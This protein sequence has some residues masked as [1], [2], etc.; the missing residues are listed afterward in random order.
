MNLDNIKVEVDQE[1]NGKWLGWCDQYQIVLYGENEG[2][3]REKIYQVIQDD[4][5]DIDLNELSATIPSFEDEDRLG[6][7]MIKVILRYLNISEE[8][9]FKSLE[10]DKE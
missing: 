7:K 5:Q 8:E 4:L 2:D 1:E 10:E 9:F 6:E 3:V